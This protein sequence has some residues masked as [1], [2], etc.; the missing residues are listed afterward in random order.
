MQPDA[1]QRIAD[2]QCAI[3]HGVKDRHDAELV[4]GRKEALPGVIPDDEPKIAD[5]TL[6]AVNL[7]NMIC[8]EDQLG[9]W[10]V[11]GDEPPGG[12]ERDK[13]LGSGVDPS[14][15]GDP[16][17]S[18]EAG[19]LAFALGLSC[20][21]QHGMAQPDGALGPHRLRVRPAECHVSDHLTQQYPVYR[22]AVL[23][24]HADETAHALEPSLR[25]IIA[26]MGRPKAAY[27]SRGSTR[28][29][30]T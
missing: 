3:G 19:R 13:Q 29:D 22:R 10:D 6:E 1:V 17:D 28:S 26:E 14:I 4:A 7:P 27:R 21:P 12:A 8:V 24:Q 23:L 18:V 15:R 16:D 2:H 25:A 30:T 5:E 11:W 9:V 20:G